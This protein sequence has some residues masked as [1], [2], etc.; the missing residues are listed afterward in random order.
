[1]CGNGASFLFLL[2]VLKCL[3]SLQLYSKFQIIKSAGTKIFH[4]L[5]A[6][7]SS[8]WASSAAEVVTVVCLEGPLKF[9]L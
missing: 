6:R 8:V 1:M 5:L 4:S 2:P 7:E 3:Q 9:F